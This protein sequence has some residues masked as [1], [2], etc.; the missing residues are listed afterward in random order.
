MIVNN[1][2][3]CC[4]D[5]THHDCNGILVKDKFDRPIISLRVSLTNRC[6]FNC[7]YCHHDGMLP[8][9]SEMSPDEIFQILK[10]AKKFGIKKI[11]FSGGEPLLRDDII[12]IIRK[13]SSLNFKDISIT[14][15]GVLLGKYAEDLLKAGLNRVNVSLDTLNHDTYNFITKGNYLNKVKSGILSC[16]DLGIHPIKINMVII[17]GVN[18]NEVMNMFDFC[19][20]NGL[21]LQLIELMKADNK[22]IY[23]KYHFNMNF[24][25]EKFEKMANEVKIRHF[26]QDRKK[27]YIDNG[28]IEIVKPMDNTKFCQNCTRLRIT[29]EGNIKP[30]LLKNDNLVNI[31]E[32]IRN[33][34]SENEIEKIFLKGVNNREPYYNQYPL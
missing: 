33:K 19:K 15:N 16:V 11:R 17:K 23:D 13:T 7:I 9:K 21:I 32:P 1:K 18:N 22:Q 4:E 8:S 31:I 20:S 3:S 10:I 2:L 34:L 27:Y 29:S 25:E 30:C 28:E 14:T 26:M 6:N 24:F 12:D 5:D